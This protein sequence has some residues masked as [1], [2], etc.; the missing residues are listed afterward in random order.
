MITTRK[1]G[2]IVVQFWLYACTQLETFSILSTNTEKSSVTSNNC[3]PIFPLQNP[4]YND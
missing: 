1:R 2:V 3:P 4:L